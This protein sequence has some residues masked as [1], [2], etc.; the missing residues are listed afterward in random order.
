MNI[1]QGVKSNN[2]RQTINS[3]KFIIKSKPSI[4][5]SK[6]HQIQNESPYASNQDV[7]Q[8]ITYIVNKSK[9]LS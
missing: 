4:K 5:D 1:L 8:L 7:N 2:P 3:G 6:N 9:K